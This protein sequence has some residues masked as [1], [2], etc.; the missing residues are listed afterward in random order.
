MRGKDDY[1]EA[2]LGLRLRQLRKQKRVTIKVA[3]NACG[4]SYTAL[5]QFELDDR[6]PPMDS[7]AVLASYYGVDIEYLIGS[8]DI[9]DA[10]EINVET[11]ALSNSEKELM[12]SYAT[13]DERTK[14]II[15]YII[16]V[17]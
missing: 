15:N 14:S 7:M 1:K 2:T 9:P 17:K 6:V 10:T 4:L 16:G 3:A 5:A 13:C 12:D 11:K 8:T